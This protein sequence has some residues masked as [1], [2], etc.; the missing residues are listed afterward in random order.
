MDT[1]QHT[2][3]NVW[4]VLRLCLAMTLICGWGLSG[5]P[6][7]AQDPLYL[8]D[9]STTVRDLSFEFQDHQTF[10]PD[11]LK[12]QI[13]TQAPGFWSRL[14]RWFDFVPSVD[15]RIFLFDPI[16]LQK[17]VVRLRRFYQQNGFLHPAIDYRHAVSD[18][19]AV[20]DTTSNSIDVTFFITE[21]PP[22]IIQDTGFFVPDSSNY[23]VSLF[24]GNLRREWIAFRGRTA[25]ELG[26]RYT[27]F[28]RTRIENDV[29]S[30]L[31]NQG[32]AFSNV[33]SE[34]RI[35]SSANT[36]DIRFYLD[37]GPRGR[38]DKI[39]VEGNQSVRAA[40]V[41]RQLPFQTGDR[42]SAEAVTAG[43]RQLFGLNL[44]RLVLADVP[45]QP[46]DTTV[47]VR[48]RVRESS[49][50]TLS[51]QVGFGAQTGFSLQGNWTHRNF[52]GEARTLNVGLIAETGLPSNAPAFI[53][54]FLSGSATQ[55]RSR[56]LR[57]STT[58]RQ[59]YIF[60]TGL[61]ATL[62]PFIE[63]RLN[64]KLTSPDTTRFLQLNE[65]QL[66]LN[67]TLS[68][69]ILPFR[70]A[71]LRHSLSRTQQFTL[72]TET[73]VDTT[74]SSA[75]QF[76]RSIL[77][78]SGTLGKADDYVNPTRGVL[79]R[80][81]IST[82]GTFLRSEIQFVRMSGEVTG[83]LPLSS[84][85]EIAT[86]LFGGYLWPLG[87]SRDALTVAPTAP[88]SDLRTNQTAQNRFSDFLFYAGGGTNVRGWSPQLGGGKVLRPSRLARDG[89]VYESVGAQARAGLN[90]EMRFPMPGLG[91]A[92]RAA[93]FFDSAYLTDGTLSLVPSPA[94]TDAL[95]APDGTPVASNPSRW[96]AGTGLGIRYETP[97]GFL[98]LDVATKLNPDPLDLRRPAD[99][100]DAVTRTPN[101]PDDVRRPPT[102][103]PKRTIRRF[104]L[105]FGI[106]RSF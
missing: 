97:V 18:S 38:F 57:A 32:F 75:D 53:P 90:L 81:S 64:N 1:M 4:P 50:R 2:Q 6:A 26:E 19:I 61:A 71:S 30:W 49:L 104:R 34:A 22:L 65:R 72:G 7:V 21:G 45:S 62:E 92:W 87:E 56:R 33:R 28:N 44:F 17:D 48:Y 54:D 8:V 73:A 24:S 42:F 63:E 11:R 86:R 66:G 100:A 41:R 85:L 15:P 105:H 47:T 9:D 102:A 37:P 68:Y 31:R 79:V 10:L 74:T 20:F 70:T 60:T 5:R 101:D 59:P 13:A 27:E 23:A 93:V 83:Y 55:D 58:L 82:G 3:G 52:Y 91:E 76:D 43:R 98:R 16:T 25:F 36:A 29:S 77:T 80:P 14:R 78:L 69:E 94:V 51:G 84:S 35:D 99:V 67:T 106:G 40:V 95:E 46:R 96:I 88:P 12:Q 39:L 103:A 89:F